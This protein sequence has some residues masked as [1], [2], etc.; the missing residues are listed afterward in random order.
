MS[1]EVKEVKPVH[2]LSCGHENTFTHLIVAAAV[3][4]LV[5]TFGPQLLPYAR[6]FQD[7]LLPVV[8]NLFESFNVQQPEMPDPPKNGPTRDFSND[9]SIN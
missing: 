3:V 6:S 9:P 8:D 2:I 1:D 7:N 4:T 5:R